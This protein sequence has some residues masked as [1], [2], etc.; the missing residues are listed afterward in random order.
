MIKTYLF[1]GDILRKTKIFFINGII[2]TVTSL[3]MKSI[4]MVFSLYVS[5]KIGSEA[6]GIFSLVMSV[7]MFLVVIATSGLSIACTCI[8]S[9]QFAKE[10]FLDGLKAVKSCILFG[11]L[12]GIGTSFIVLIFAN[13]ISK[14]W[15]QSMISSIPLYIISIG[16]PFISISSVI[17]G[18]F[19]AIRKGY[20][21]AVSQIF[22]LI[23]KIIVTVI[24]LASS[25]TPNVESICIYL[26][27]ANV[28]SENCSCI[29]MII[30]YR[31]DISIYT[32]RKITQITFKKR[33]FKIAF[34]VSITSYIRSGLSTLKQFIIPN[35][36]LLY[37][38]SYSMALSEYGKINGMTMAVLTF[39]N[40]FITSFSNLLIPEF[41]SL[42]A[43]KYKKRILE[44]CKKVFAVTS[45]FSIAFIIIFYVFSEK[46]S[47]MIF[48]NLECAKYIKNL[49][50][51]ILFI[52]TDNILDNM[53]K[54]LNKQVNVMTC[55]ILDLILTITILYFSLPI[56]G[57]TGY[58]LAIMISEIFNFCVSY[59]HLYRATNFK[60][61][62]S[63]AYF[64][65]LFAIIWFYNIV[66]IYH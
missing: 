50:P 4:G 40:V 33:I 41:S 18:Y 26:I 37:G 57:L 29:L 42:A 66:I 36:L 19:S 45:L 46:I 49:S 2:L 31:K 3:V 28:I 7:Y 34:P 22:E 58:L 38:L 59:F 27:L 12:L 61:P 13:A 54:G 63:L 53:L 39:P 10:N 25:S 47:L 5:N 44:V 15:L 16:L 64:Y 23:I 56:L 24:L 20:K 21:S 62:L 8:V 48:K 51:V 14:I 65:V 60:I 32:S 55:N 30:L 35:R 6:I 1:N 43:Q 11:L 9:E 52:Y 17:N